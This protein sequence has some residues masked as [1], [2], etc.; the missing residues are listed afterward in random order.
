MQFLGELLLG[1]DSRNFDWRYVREVHQVPERDHL[2]RPRIAG[3]NVHVDAHVLEYLAGLACGHR[4]SDAA[5]SALALNRLAP[6]DGELEVVSH[7]QPCRARQHLAKPTAACAPRRVGIGGCPSAVTDPGDHRDSALERPAA[8]RRYGGDAGEQALERGFLAQPVQRQAGGDMLGTQPSF[9]GGSHRRGGGI[10]CRC[11]AGSRA[12]G[13][14]APIAWR[15]WT[16]SASRSMALARRA[17]VVRPSG[18]GHG[19]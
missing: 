13:S 10:P 5:F 18:Q 12:A 11:H 3:D 1:P 8:L 7:L 14:R 4:E 2:Y 15:I 6:A 19:P 17:R 9:Q 16:W